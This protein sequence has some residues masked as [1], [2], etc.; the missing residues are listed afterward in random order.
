MDKESN[1]SHKKCEYEQE[2]PQAQIT[3][4]PWHNEDVLH[5]KGILQ[6]K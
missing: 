5:T 3:T 6:F 4:N 1:F 2:M